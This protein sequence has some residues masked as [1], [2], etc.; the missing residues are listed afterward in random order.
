MTSGVSSMEEFLTCP[1]CLD[2]AVD[3]FESECCSKVYCGACLKTKYKDCPTCRHSP[4]ALKPNLVVRKMVNSLPVDCACGTKVMRGNLKDHLTLCP[5]TIHKC[6]FNCC[7]FEDKTDNFLNHIQENH[8]KDLISIF[9]GGEN[10]Q[11]PNKKELDPIITRRNSKGRKAR[12]GESGKYYCGG[13]GCNDI[14]CCDGSCGPTNGCNCAACM[15]LDIDVRQLP[16]RYWVNREGAVCRKSQG[17]IYC[18]RKMDLF[19][20]DGY[21]GPTNGPS[22]DS[23]KILNHQLDNLYKNVNKS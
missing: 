21:C 1:I 22:C 6:S 20:S 9:T 23:C 17:K 12:L 13:T 8:R 7:T 15:Q 3:A 16:P 4:F 18:G 14:G 10:H 11:N 2:V 19:H 5:Q